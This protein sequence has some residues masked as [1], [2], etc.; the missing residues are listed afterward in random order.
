MTSIPEDFIHYKSTP[1]FTNT[2][3][4]KMF[5]H[6]HNTKAGVYGKI[7]VTKGRLAFFGFADRRGEVER[8]CII[9]AETSAISPPEYW[10]KVEF[11]TA[12]TEFHVDFYAQQASDIVKYHLSERNDK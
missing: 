11:L 2:T 3:I 8:E 4:P 7:C 10:H 1:T 5:L 6:L 12:D 9:E